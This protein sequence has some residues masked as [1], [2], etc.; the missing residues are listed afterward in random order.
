MLGVEPSE[1]HRS[2]SP[3]AVRGTPRQM[4]DQLRRRRDTTGVTYYA[5]DQTAVDAPAP[6]VGLLAGRS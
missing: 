1:M 4:A 2:G 3:G 5:V 6:A